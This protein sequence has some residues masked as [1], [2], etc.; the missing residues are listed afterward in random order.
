MNSVWAPASSDVVETKRAS[1]N[2]T[3]SIRKNAHT[4]S[5]SQTGSRECEAFAGVER[6]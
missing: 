3:P 1:F 6:T 5:T 2:L 4:G